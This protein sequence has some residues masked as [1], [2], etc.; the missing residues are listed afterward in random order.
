MGVKYIC[1]DRNLV[2]CDQNRY[3]SSILTPNALYTFITSIY[4]QTIL[5]GNYWSK[6][7]QN[8]KH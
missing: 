7:I 2:V 8:G 6:S 5:N 3:C 4:I 1:K